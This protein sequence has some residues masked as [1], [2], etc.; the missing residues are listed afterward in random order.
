MMGSAQ[1]AQSR[2][3]RH[4]GGQKL[5]FLGL[6]LFLGQDALSFQFGQFLQLADRVDRRRRGACCWA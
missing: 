5:G 1:G 6:N 4:S 2:M 3:G